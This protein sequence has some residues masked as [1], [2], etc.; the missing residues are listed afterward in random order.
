MEQFDL[1]VVG[2]GPGGY[3]TAERAGQAGLRT[4]V[5]EKNKLGGVCLNEG[6]IPSKTFLHA[7]K[8]LSYAEHGGDYGVSIPAGSQIDHKKVL[9]RKKRVVNRLVAGVKAQLRTANVTVLQAE[10]QILGRDGNAYLV[11]AAE[12]TFAAK[13][14]V[15]AT[16]S[17]PLL[18]HIAGLTESLAAGFAVTSREILDLTE[19]PARLTVVGGGVVGLE[20]AAYYAAAG[21]AVTVVEYSD[22]IAGA[23]DA[24]IRD[25]LQKSLEKSGI[26]FLLAA[27]VTEIANGTVYFETAEG[28]FTLE[29][30]K[31]LV[32]AGRRPNSMNIGLETLGV[33]TENGAVVTDSQMQTNVKNVYAV[34]DIN[35]KM[36]LAH[37]AY[38]EAEVAVNHMLGRTDSMRYNAVPAVIYTNPEAAWV[39]ETA[40]SAAA[41]GYRVLSTSLPLAYAGRYVAENATLT[42]LCKLVINQETNTLL[43]AHVIGAYASEYIVAAGS[44]I[45][46][47]TDI[48]EIKRIIFPHPTVSEILRESLFHI[49]NN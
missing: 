30:D 29:T 27:K 12:E 25:V 44:F 19:V 20:M 10:A 45:G 14:L 1:I 21:S 3:L 5:I 18:P 7:A 34:G 40:E 31:V 6:C 43:G 46:L 42:G 22:K 28:A 2:G 16:G 33:A 23:V 38:R 49:P 4:L 24:D 37:T 11:A 35:G 36:M 32:A 39:G 17:S 47:N 41:K 8:I 13:R 26:R 9:E 48:E 15:L